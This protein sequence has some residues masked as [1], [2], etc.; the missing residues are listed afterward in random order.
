MPQENCEVEKEIC[1][2]FAT[3]GCHKQF[4]TVQKIKENPKSKVHRLC[5]Q[6]LCTTCV[7]KM[8]ATRERRQE[9]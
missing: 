9:R 8:R 4:H 2:L 6:G 7:D 5:F 3:Q 1:S